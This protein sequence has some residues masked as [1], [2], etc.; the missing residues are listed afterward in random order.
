MASQR[1]Q[2][3]VWKRHLHWTQGTSYLPEEENEQTERWQPGWVQ[4]T[5]GVTC[6]E[7]AGESFA[8]TK[9]RT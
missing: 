3:L 8:C 7:V 9:Q 4:N 2:R 1:I 5:E 6:V